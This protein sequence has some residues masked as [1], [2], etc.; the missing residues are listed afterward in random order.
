MAKVFRAAGIDSD[1][2]VS[3]VNKKG[4]RVLSED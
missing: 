4:I 1:V 2:F 3:Q